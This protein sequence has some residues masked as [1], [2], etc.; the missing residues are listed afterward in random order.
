MLE[1]VKYG[2]RYKTIGQNIA[3]EN[4]KDYLRKNLQME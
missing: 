3:I 2:E 1:S 4:K